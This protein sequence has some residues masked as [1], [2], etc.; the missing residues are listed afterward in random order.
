MCILFICSESCHRHTHMDCQLQI[1][2][3]EFPT[4]RSGCDNMRVWVVYFRRLVWLLRTGCLLSSSST[5][6]FHSPQVTHIW[7]V[8]PANRHQNQLTRE[9]SHRTRVNLGLKPLKEK[10]TQSKCMFRLGDDDI[11]SPY[12]ICLDTF[13]FC[14]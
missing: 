1:S 11:E 8:G 9:D 2:R 10:K 4:T 14:I 6:V 12:T 7:W 13:D 5:C 3:T